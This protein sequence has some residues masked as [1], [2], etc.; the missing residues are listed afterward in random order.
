MA[1][2][3]SSSTRTA[4]VVGAGPGGS[5]AALLLAATG[6]SVTLLERVA[7]PTAVGAGILL[8]PNGLAVLDGLGLHDAL[9][10]R[11]HELHSATIR[12]HRGRV[13][14]RTRVPDLGAGL[15]HLVAVRRS[16]LA[17]VLGDAIGARA[18]IDLRTG[19]EVVRA[20]PEGSVI[21]RSGDTEHELEAELVVAADGVRSQVRET[22][23]FAA[24]R[25]DT[26]HTYLRVVVESPEELDTSDEQG[27]HWT[28]LGLF[29]ASPL[30]DGTTYFFADADAPSV[31]AALDA[32]DMDALRSAWAT[33][34][35]AS[36]PLFARV[37]G[38]EDLLVNQVQRV[39]A[40]SFCNGRVVLLGDAAHAMAPNLGQGANSALVD[41]GVLALEL[42]DSGVASAL[43]AYDARR[44]PSVRKVQR[45]CDRVARAAGLRNGFARSV[46]DAL[47]SHTPASASERRFRAVQQ[48][49]PASLLDAVRELV[50]R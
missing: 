1:T 23:G 21:Y 40:P 16:H 43:D 17:T 35:P 50:T 46:R 22:A 15:D 31:R 26:T 36:E 13:L 39:D 8:Q 48:E 29:G 34:L 5:A 27:E 25:Q 7:E 32:H 2:S 41:A 42:A 28:P 20:S 47:I 44:R 4:V 45:D 49:D 24:T 9:H 14:L 38:V 37:G 3:P 11:A 33:V 18:G 10:G 30:G 6:W 19:A 12:N